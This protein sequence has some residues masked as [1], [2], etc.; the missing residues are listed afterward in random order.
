[1]QVLQDGMRRWSGEEAG[2]GQQICAAL[3]L[4]APSVAGLNLEGPQSVLQALGVLAAIVTVHECGHFSMARLLGIHV[5]Q[6]AI[7]F[8]PKLVKY[9][10]KGVEYS[11]RVIPLGGFVG[12]PDDDPNSSFSPDD[13]DLLKNRSI[14]DRALVISAGIIA[15]IIFAYSVLFAQA[16]TVGLLEQKFR[17]GVL[18]P[19]VMLSSSGAKAGLKGGDVVVAVNGSSLGSEEAAVYE[20]VDSIKKSPGKVMAFELQRGEQTVNIQVIPDRSFDGSGKIGVQLSPNVDTRRVRTKSVLD[21][22][23]YAWFE[24][25]RL[26]N[27]VV[28][29][30]R[31]IVFN[32]AQTADKLSGPV[33]IVAVGAE[34]ARSDSAGLFQFAA[35]VNINLAVVNVLPLPALDGGYLALIMLEA[36]RGGKKLPDGVEQ[37]IMSSG[38]LLL[39]AIGVVLM[40]RDTLNLGFLQE[41]RL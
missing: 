5:T 6:F 40:V 9:Q 39:L 25:A 41:M 12:F 27:V 2:R 8:G 26:T 28:D 22:A 34:V 14:R 17:P 3:L 23:K 24:F 13:P 1:M 32:F 10:A 19:E 7:G 15:N 20:L 31:Q 37:G 35:I 18:I 29:G 21:A 30:L 11:L 36:F 4:G 38:I 16:Q 33:A